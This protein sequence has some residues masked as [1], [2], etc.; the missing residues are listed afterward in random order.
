MFWR[1]KGGSMGRVDGFP[2]A[3]EDPRQG[4]LSAV[5]Q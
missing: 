2:G 5:L 3:G 1:L 4:T